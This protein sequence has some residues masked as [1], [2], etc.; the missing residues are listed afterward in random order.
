[1]PKLAQV[2]VIYGTSGH[3]RSTPMVMTNWQAMTSY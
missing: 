2:K 3:Q 1:V